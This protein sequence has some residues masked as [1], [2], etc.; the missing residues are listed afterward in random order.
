MI[1]RLRPK[2]EFSRDVL[3][4]MTGSTIAQA[5]PIAITPILTRLYMPEDFGVLALFV[6]VTAILGSIANGCYEFAIML[7][8][9][10]E[11]S[12]NIA[13]L[14]LLIALCFS[15]A[16]LILAVF[17]NTQIT[18]LLGNQGI[19]FWLYFMPFVVLMTGLYNVLNY[20]NT[21]KKFYKDISNSSVYRATV[22]AGVQI[23]I[24]LLKSG[25]AGLITG[26]I[27]S[28]LVANLQL[29]LNVKREYIIIRPRLEKLKLLGIR[30]KDFFIY[31]TIGKLSNVSAHYA[32]NILISAIYNVTSLG[33]F[34]LG[35]RVL[36]IPSRVVGSSI[37]Q[38]FYQAATEEMQEKGSATQVYKQ[39]ILKLSIFSIVFFFPAYFFIEDIFAFIFG[40]DWEVS[41]KIAVLL[42]PLIAT[43]FIASTLS[44][45]FNVFEKQKLLLYWQ[46]L[47]LMVSIA[48]IFVSSWMS[49]PFLD[50]IRIYSWLI[51]FMYVLYVF[52]SFRISRG[53]N[54]K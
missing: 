48:I 41:G 18:N 13:A 24:G 46:V 19:S 4:L 5:I 7:P 12:I 49:L 3:T 47:L 53:N 33:Y 45:V 32:M 10:D 43:Q 28:Q 34:Y 11:D 17:F 25:A 9:Q 23:F 42:L 35:Q 51:S 21:R 26:Q 37:S 22:G 20:L 40:N 29:M 16:L 52:L 27:F 6:A 1:Q 31:S 30:Y 14:G 50:F 44:P 39:T 2:S 15:A 36:I 8:E 38:V 54:T